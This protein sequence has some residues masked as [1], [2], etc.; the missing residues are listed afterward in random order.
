MPIANRFNLLKITP[1]AGKTV[2]VLHSQK[3]FVH[4]CSTYSNQEFL[5]KGTKNIFFVACQTIP[6][7]TLKSI[8]SVKIQAQNC[9]SQE[10]FCL[11]LLQN[12]HA[13]P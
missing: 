7:N 6:R 10:K 11:K 12:T 5:S 8:W 4:E 3:Q 9:A 1:V 13:A 2:E